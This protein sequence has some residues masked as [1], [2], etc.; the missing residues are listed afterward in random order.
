MQLYIFIHQKAASTVFRFAELAAIWTLSS[1]LSTGSDQWEAFYTT[2]AET[3]AATPYWQRVFES[4]QTYGTLNLFLNVLPHIRFSICHGSEETKKY[5]PRR[6]FKKLMCVGFPFTIL[7]SAMPYAKIFL[8]CPQHKKSCN[9]SSFSLYYLFSNFDDL[10]QL[11]ALLWKELIEW[12]PYYIRLP[13]T[14]K[15]KL[16]NTVHHR[17]TYSDMLSLV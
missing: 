11:K 12:L 14:F 1:L 17:P 5:K 9:F 2:L 3:V 13:S 7:V 10:M 4:L 15:S 8:K 6:H 16:Q